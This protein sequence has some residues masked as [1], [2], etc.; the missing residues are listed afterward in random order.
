MVGQIVIRPMRSGDIDGIIAIDRLILGRE[1]AISWQQNIDSYLRVYPLRCMVAE[2]DKK[3]AGFLLGDVSNWEYGLPSCAWIQIVGVTPEHQRKGIG[4]KLV[5]AFGSQC[6]DDGLKCVQALIR[7]D[8]DRL[9]SFFSA[10]GFK[11]GRLL[12]LQQE[13]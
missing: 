2:V 11:Q 6:K 4:K 5:E 3:V 1:R 12:N 9:D 7:G 10:A 8:D 13:I